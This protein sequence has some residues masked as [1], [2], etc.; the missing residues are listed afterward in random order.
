MSYLYTTGYGLYKN[1]KYSDARDF[2]RFITLSDPTDRRSWIG[3]GASY[4]MMKLYKESIECYSVAAMQNP[5][6]PY[7]HLY[8]A[9]CFHYLGEKTRSVATLDSA[10]S[11]AESTQASKDLVAKIKYL[12]GRWSQ[13]G[14]ND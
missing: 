6:D 5:N 13:G 2:F 7:V 1:G 10:I 14:N 12:R 11:I 4:Q 3:L 8:A 9:E